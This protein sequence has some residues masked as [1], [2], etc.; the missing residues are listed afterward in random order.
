M[1][2]IRQYV[3]QLEK[4]VVGVAATDGKLLWRYDR[5]RARGGNVHTAL[6]K[7]DKVF[8]S[9][10]WGSGCALIQLVPD[11]KEFKVKEIYTANHPFNSW[12]GSSVLI[13]EH[14]YTCEGM[15]IELPTGRLVG[16][17]GKLVATGRGGVMTCAPVGS[18][19]IARPTTC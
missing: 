9:C 13:G 16:R 8:C 18:W 17:I 11:K 6:V 10:G 7:G 14:V 15:D 19:F 1:G 12:L 3:N 5:I 4:G 2:G